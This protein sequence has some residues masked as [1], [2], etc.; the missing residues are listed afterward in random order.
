MT[1]TQAAVMCMRIMLEAAM[2]G[3]LA[4]WL[5]CGGAD[6]LRHGHLHRGIRCRW[7]NVGISYWGIRGETMVRTSLTQVCP[8]CRKVR[9][10]DYRGRLRPAVFGLAD[11]DVYAP[12]PYKQA[13][14]AP[15]RVPGGDGASCS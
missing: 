8:A 4:W 15:S 14:A 6:A 1:D 11:S 9:Q 5:L 2:L 13:E 10:T 3:A 12:F 7:T